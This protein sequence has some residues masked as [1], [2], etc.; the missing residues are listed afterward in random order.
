MRYVKAATRHPFRRLLRENQMDS[1]AYTPRLP[2]T[3]A[4]AGS[5]ARTSSQQPRRAV[6][7][8]NQAHASSP[9]IFQRALIWIKGWVQSRAK[10]AS[11]NR[12]LSPFIKAAKTNSAIAISPE[13]VKKLASALADGASSHTASLVAET[14]RDSV[15]SLDLAGLKR[16]QVSLRSGTPSGTQCEKTLLETVECSI[17]DAKVKEAKRNL[18]EALTKF[19]Q[20][21]AKPF[22]LDFVVS[23]IQH[24]LLTIVD[25][26]Q[27]AGRN[28]TAAGMVEF[29]SASSVISRQA[30]KTWFDGH[31][32]V[33]QK[34]VKTN[35]WSIANDFSLTRSGARADQAMHAFCRTA[36]TLLWPDD[37]RHAGLYD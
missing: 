34:R 3:Q 37:K 13:H 6:S 25:L 23:A 35:L 4:P 9:N 5:A 1:I 22:E 11:L 7:L 15:R 18:S 36:T 16:L 32:P 19:S 21:S 14:V 28:A 31:S 2:Y 30:L 27:P 10:A 17:K 12:A 29:E 33:H 8:P 24:N 20:S 26:V